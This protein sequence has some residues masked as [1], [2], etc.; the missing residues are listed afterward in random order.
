MVFNLK[1]L[2]VQSV[3][4]PS[5]ALSPSLSAVGIWHGVGDTRG[6][7]RGVGCIA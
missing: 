1:M 2:S 4:P 3:F 5:V 6:L 7:G